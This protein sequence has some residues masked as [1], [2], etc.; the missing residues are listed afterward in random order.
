MVQ[1]LCLTVYIT[2]TQQTTTT[3]NMCKRV[4]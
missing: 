2:D 1:F 3:I 4:V